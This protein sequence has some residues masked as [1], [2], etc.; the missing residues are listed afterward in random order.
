[1]PASAVAELGVVRLH[2]TLPPMKRDMDI[3]RLLLMEQ[4]TGEPQ[5]E[6]GK[7]D[8]K[9]VEY[10]RAQAVKEG[11]LDGHVSYDEGNEIA[12]VAVSGITPAG[13][14]FL[15][16]PS[17]TRPHA[18]IRTGRAVWWIVAG[19]IALLSGVWG[20]VDHWAWIQAF[21]SGASTRP[22]PLV[23]PVK[24]SPEPAEASGSPA[25]AHREIPDKPISTP[26][27]K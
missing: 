9:L 16:S 21:L 15:D 14:A 27:P 23:E 10:N 1:M 18:A 19:I 22:V 11:L 5:K 26:T 25:N 20:V 3:V 17:P 7:H 8:E 6:L 13:H 12:F 24:K 4:E 2:R